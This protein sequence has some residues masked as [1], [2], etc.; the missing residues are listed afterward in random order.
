V[1]PKISI[2]KLGEYMTATPSR[3]KQIL[4][5]QKN[6]SAFK[7]ARYK[8][9]RATI[10]EFMEQG[11]ASVDEA[12]S[13]A[14]ELRKDQSGTDFAVQD[15]QLSAEAIDDF[16]SISEEIEIDD[17]SVHG[18]DTFASEVID[19][20]GTKVSMRPDAILKNKKTGAIVGCVKLN[21]SKS[22]PLQEKSA[23]YVATALRAHLE[24]NLSSLE[25]VDP[26]K[27]YV[28]DVP[29]GTVC[30]AP[31]ANKKR[32]SDLVAAGEEISARWESV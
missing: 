6:P 24:V 32:L 17:L 19:F 5:D 15:R 7:A 31:K 25:H 14:A 12:H 22:S 28:V 11:M 10:V 16:L 21:F 1:K 3:R 23:A 27:C 26:A 20:G 29:T 9:A 18:G 2:N 30:S 4:R 13:T 8:D